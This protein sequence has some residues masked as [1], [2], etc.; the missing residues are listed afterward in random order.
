MY[1][2]NKTKFLKHSVPVVYKSRFITQNAWS[3]K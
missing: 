2:D 3:E 1:K